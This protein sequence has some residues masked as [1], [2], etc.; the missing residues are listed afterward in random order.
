MRASQKIGLFL[1]PF[2]FLLFLLTE[3]PQGLDLAGWRTAGV[4]LFMAILWITEAIPIPATALL[5]LVFFPVLGIAPIKDSAAPFANPLI[6]LFMG[7]FIVALGMQRWNLHRRIALN[8]IRIIGMNPKRL[9]AGFMLA[10]A[11]LSMWVSN[12]ATTM[13]MLPIGLS[14]VELA[15]SGRNHESPDTPFPFALALLLGIAYACSIGGLGTLIGTPPNAL[16]AGFMYENYG[17]SIGFAQWMLVGV[18]LIIIGLPLVF[19]VLTSLVFPIRIKTLAGGKDYIQ[20]EL[21]N[22]G[23]ITGPEKKVAFVFALVGFLWV[24][25]PLMAGLVPGLSDAGIAIFAATLMFVIP[26]NTGKG[27]F[28]LEWTYAE[29]L[30]WGVL[31]LFGG[32][33]SLASAISKTGLSDWIGN[34][35]VLIKTWPL[36]AVVLIVSFIIIMLTELT[37]NTATAAAFLPIMASVA[38]SIGENPLMLVIPAA[39]AA[40]CAFMLPVATPPNAIV[41]GSGRVTIPQMARAGMVLNLSF[42]ILITLVSFTLVQ[43][44]FGIQAG[45]LPEWTSAH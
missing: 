36:V 21:K 41:Y 2:F 33:L 30:P 34:E 45:V 5:P 40:S 7:G 31:L 44:V 8:I 27:Q 13:M 15:L 20:S 9:I 43:W 32:G 16:L 25:R 39:V 3:P 28:L 4:G 24:I 10:S 37:S 35:L 14:V 12:T 6:F 23:P 42:V 22:L 18:P 38:V 17:L 19:W 26:S 1:A 11:F 29:K